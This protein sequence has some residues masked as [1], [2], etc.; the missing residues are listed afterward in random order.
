VVLAP[1]YPETKTASF[2]NDVATVMTGLG[3]PPVFVPCFL[4]YGGNVAAYKSTLGAKM[5][6]ASNWGNRSPAGNAVAT[7]TALAADAHGRGLIWMQPISFQDV[8]PD[9]FVYAEPENT[10]N[11]RLTWQAARDGNAEWVQCVTWNDFSEGTQ[12][13]PSRDHG[14]V[15]TELNGWF[16]AWWKTG[17][18]PTIVHD[19][20][21]LTHRKHPY[22]ATATGGMSHYMSLWQTT[23]AVNTVECFARLASSGTVTLTSGSNVSIVTGSGIQIITAPLVV[24]SAPYATLSR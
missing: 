4:N 6:G 23:A 12:F 3:Q 9:Q 18:M 8:R 2:Y 14:A 21:I 17:S 19:S 24:G 15:L 20:L 5:I 7:N 16:I 1:F 22:A 10:H 13:V 11:L